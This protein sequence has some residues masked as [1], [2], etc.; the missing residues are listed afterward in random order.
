MDRVT[1]EKLDQWFS[2]D[3]VAAMSA[4]NLLGNIGLGWNDLNLKG[5]QSLY[6]TVTRLHGKVYG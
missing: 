3:E 4:F 6:T 1:E 2:N 5:K